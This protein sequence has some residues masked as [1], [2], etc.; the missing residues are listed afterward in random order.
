MQSAEFREV[1]K[2]LAGWDQLLKDF[3][4]AKRELLERLGSRMLADVRERIGGTGKVRGWQDRYIGSKNGYVANRPK[5]ETWQVT[6]GGGKYAVGYIT[7]A[8]ENGHRVR[9]PQPSGSPA[10]SGKDS[11]HYTRGRN[12]MAAVSG[13][14]FY[15]SVR[16]RMD[17]MGREELE[18]L[19]AEVARRLES[20]A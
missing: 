18:K 2:L 1:D 4:Q 6:K 9:R 10:G 16:T 8:I 14:R 12:N 11:Y 19:A 5:A 13:K 17:S 20:A 15:E 3:P 7:N